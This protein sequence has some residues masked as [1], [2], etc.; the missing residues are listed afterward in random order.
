[1]VCSLRFSNALKSYRDF[2][3]IIFGSVPE[4]FVYFRTGFGETILGDVPETVGC[5]AVK[6]NDFPEIL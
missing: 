2:W 5:F 4:L 1:M 6:F 3:K